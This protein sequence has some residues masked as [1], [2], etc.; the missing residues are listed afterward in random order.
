MTNEAPDPDVAAGLDLL[1]TDGAL[2]PLR[3]MLPAT[4]GLRMAA[5]LAG[6]A[7]ARRPSRCRPRRGARPHRGGPLGGGSPPQGQAV[8]A[9][10]VVAEPAAAPPRADP[11]RGRRCRD[12]AGRGL[13]ARLG[14]PRAG[15]VRG[16]QPRR[17]PRPEQQRAQP[18][19]L[20]GGDRH[21]WRE[22]RA[23]GP[24]AR[25]RPVRAAAGAVDGGA[26]RV[27]G[28]DGPGRDTGRRGAAGRRCSNS[29]STC[30]RP[31][32]C[33]TSRSSSSRRRSTSTTSPTS[34]PDAA[35]SS[36]SCR[37]G[38]QVFLMSWRNPEAEHAAW[39]LDTYGQAVLDAMDACERITRTSRTSL[40]AFCSGG[41]ITAM[42][43]AH[44]AAIGAQE[45]VASV[46]FAVTVLDQERAGTTGALLDPETARTAVGPPPAGLPRRPHPRR[47]VRVAAPERPDLVLLGE[48]LPARRA[49]ESR[50]TSCTGTP[51]PPA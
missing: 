12:R 46:T 33:A 31:R 2:G 30:R 9:S 23:R 34:L 48:Q 11:H 16:R 21:P 37:G 19:G 41:M 49:A 44:L 50:S 43:L 20:A 8:R 35:S 36:T 42:L 17:R 15:A 22:R 40:M 47:G 39:D 45:R 6:K 29:S 14:R 5:A 3:R 38:Q 1:L 18:G 4:S 10:R 32:G 7:G 25:A 28:R 24:P 13:R 27:H 51:T 26:R